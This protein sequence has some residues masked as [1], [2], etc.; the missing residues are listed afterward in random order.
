M[1]YSLKKFF[2]RK[3]FKTIL[4]LPLVLTF[5][6][7]QNNTAN[8]G[9]EFQWD[10][11]Q[12]YKKL[13]WTQKNGAKRAKNKI[14]FF[15]RPS[16]RRTGFIKLNIKV[17]DNFKTKLKPEKISLC[18]VNIGGYDSRTKCLEKISTDI[19][20]ND[21]GKNIDIYPVKPVPSSKESFAVVF[22]VINPQRAGLYQFH[23]FSKSSGT[24]PVSSYLGSWTIKVDQY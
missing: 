20:I 13:K 22:N 1:Y 14:F 9:L 11:N 8:A 15:L 6:P 12:N 5:I 2:I 17:P 21:N 18:R 10:D 23:S 3:S 16:D 4:T 7:F 19:E 24:I